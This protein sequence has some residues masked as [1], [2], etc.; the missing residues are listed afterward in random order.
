MTI[1]YMDSVTR[2]MGDIT[3]IVLASQSGCY[4]I[5]EDGDVWHTSGESEH[6]KSMSVAYACYQKR[7]HTHLKL[8]IMW[9]TNAVVN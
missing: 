4:T 2:V 3:R 8:K 7:F 1:K 6:V 9:F 5:T